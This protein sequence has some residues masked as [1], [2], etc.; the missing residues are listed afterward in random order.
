[1]KTVVKFLN[2]NIGPSLAKNLYLL[3]TYLI[4]VNVIDTYL[5]QMYFHGNRAKGVGLQVLKLSY[6]S[7]SVMTLRQSAINVSVT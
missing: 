3:L 1:M 6:T 7:L 5:Q 2:F 4:A